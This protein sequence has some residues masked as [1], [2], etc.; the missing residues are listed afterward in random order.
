MKY[1]YTILNVE[2]VAE[3]IEFYETAFGFKRKFITPEY[4]YGELVSGDT[5]ISF[6]SVEL[7]NS[8]F[9]KGIQ[10]TISPRNLMEMHNPHVF[11]NTDYPTAL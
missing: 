8:N 4:D 5:A 1:A 3:I 6:A 7:G 10:R 9:K 2:S 11:N